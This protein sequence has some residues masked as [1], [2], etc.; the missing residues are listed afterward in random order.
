MAND[1]KDPR[2]ATENL[3]DDPEQLKHIIRL[4]LED[5]SRN[6]QKCE[7]A[8]NAM[9]SLL[10]SWRWRVG[11]AVMSFAERA[12]RRKPV[13]LATDHVIDLLNRISL[14]HRQ[15][16]AFGVPAFLLASAFLLAEGSDLQ[17]FSSGKDAKKVTTHP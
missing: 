6:A 1:D 17:F 15:R 10:S 12:L 11:N 7:E 4:I 9:K 8:L 16:D 5:D 2:W 14:N 13:R 3:P